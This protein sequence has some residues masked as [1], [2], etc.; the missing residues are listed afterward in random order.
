MGD[1]AKAIHKE[2]KQLR[3]WFVGMALVTILG[4]GAIWY[5]I[6]QHAQHQNEVLLQHFL[7]QLPK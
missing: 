6:V 7:N 1:I 2:F 3:F 4:T 5:G